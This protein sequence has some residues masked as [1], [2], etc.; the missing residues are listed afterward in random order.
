MLKE[1]ELAE[2]CHLQVEILN[3]LVLPMICLKDAKN[4]P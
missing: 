3:L 1:M 4:V 2:I